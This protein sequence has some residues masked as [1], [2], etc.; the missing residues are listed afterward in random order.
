MNVLTLVLH[1][2]PR[3]ACTLVGQSHRRDVHWATVQKPTDPSITCPRGPLAPTDDRAGTMNKES[4][5]V[6]VPSLRYAAKA[7][8]A[9]AG[10][11]LGDEAEPGSKLPSRAKLVGIDD[12]WRRSHSR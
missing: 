10:S 3:Y 7:L 9:P 1:Q 8:F 12:G 5:K 2:R 6:A 11:L 4:T